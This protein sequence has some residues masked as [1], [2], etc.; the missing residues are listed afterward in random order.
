MVETI[1]AWSIKQHLPRDLILNAKEFRMNFNK[2]I[3]ISSESMCGGKI[4]CGIENME[5]IF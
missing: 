2:S 5:N 1:S 4:L 3:V